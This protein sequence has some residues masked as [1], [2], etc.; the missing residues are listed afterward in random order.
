MQDFINEHPSLVEKI[1]GVQ[2]IRET[3]YNDLL[4]QNESAL[5]KQGQIE[6]TKIETL[7]SKVDSVM[8]FQSLK[9]LLAH[10][11]LQM[12]ADRTGCA[13]KEEYIVTHEIPAEKRK[14]LQELIQNG[15]S[16]SN[17][18]NMVEYLHDNERLDIEKLHSFELDV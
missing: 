15:Q 16:N 2:C 3:N 17:Y 12:M 9:L 7:R 8:N 11:F 10:D 1:S 13:S 18:L 5:K 4:S 6:I 14:A